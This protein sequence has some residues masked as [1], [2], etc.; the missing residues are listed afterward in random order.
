MDTIQ[1][2]YALTNTWPT[3]AL[4]EFV[5]K[6]TEGLDRLRGFMFAAVYGAIRAGAFPKTD[7]IRLRMA[8]AENNDVSDVVDGLL[9]VMQAFAGKTTMDVRY[10]NCGGEPSCVECANGGE[11]R[12]NGAPPCQLHVHEVIDRDGVKVVDEGC[13]MFQ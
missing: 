7:Y 10:R 2:G 3:L 13:Y 11:H 9:V 12:E 8:V 6:N 1:D 4:A 5:T